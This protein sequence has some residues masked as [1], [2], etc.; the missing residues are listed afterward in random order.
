MRTKRD[1][2]LRRCG[3]DEVEMLSI[4]FII[5]ESKHDRL[6][7]KNIRHNQTDLETQEASVL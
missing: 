1:M 6:T 7:R 5:E 3:R 4:S 2:H